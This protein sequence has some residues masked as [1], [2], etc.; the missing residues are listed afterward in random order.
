MKSFSI[1]RQRMEAYCSAA[2]RHRPR[3]LPECGAHRSSRSAVTAAAA[4]RRDA[5]DRLD[6]QKDAGSAPSPFRIS[7][8]GTRARSSP[9]SSTVNGTNPRDGR[10]AITHDNLFTATHL[11]EI[12]G[13]VVSQ[14]RNVRASHGIL[15]RAHDSHKRPLV[16]A[17]GPPSRPSAT[18]RGAGSSN[19]SDDV[20]QPL[21][22]V[23][24]STHVRCARPAIR[25]RICVFLSPWDR[26]DRAQATVRTL[27]LPQTGSAESRPPP[28]CLPEPARRR[29][30]SG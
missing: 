17:Q 16:P 2:Q 14:V 3:L 20:P 22:L 6:L 10:V 11:L 4:R 30:F 15:T 21:D 23:L 13:Q 18:T 5:E 28:A 9:A 29:A 27:V 7:P 19:Q 24:Y 1:T 8:A 25:T 26:N 12:L